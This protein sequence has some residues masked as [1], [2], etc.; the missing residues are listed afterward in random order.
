M[1]EINIQ[2]LLS[3]TNIGCL[4]NMMYANG[5]YLSVSYCGCQP[6]TATEVLLTVT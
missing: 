5:L 4:K 6:F 1:V 2:L 3:L